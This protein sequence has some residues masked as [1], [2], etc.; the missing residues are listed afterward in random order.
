MELCSF[1]ITGQVFFKILIYTFFEKKII[2]L[3]QIIMMISLNLYIHLY[4][5]VPKCI[6]PIITHIFKKIT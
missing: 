2:Q 1:T 5:P 4:L 6:W 3:E